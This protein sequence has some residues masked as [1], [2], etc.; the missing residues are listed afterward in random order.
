MFGTAGCRYWF[1]LGC[2]NR[3]VIRV[4]VGLV[5]S[6]RL[7]IVRRRLQVVGAV[8]IVLVRVEL[9]VVVVVAEPMVLKLRFVV[10]P[11]CG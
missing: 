3:E 5:V 1:L 11:Q 9:V 4:V 7:R 2:R 10:L 6:F 8:V